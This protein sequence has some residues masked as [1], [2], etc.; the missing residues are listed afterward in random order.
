MVEFSY[1]RI[2][3]FEN[4][5]LWEFRPF[6]NSIL[7]EFDLLRF[8]LLRF[9]LMRFDL[10]SAPPNIDSFNFESNDD[11]DKGT[12]ETRVDSNI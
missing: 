1:G 7:W 12:E 2:R 9:E 5:T 4:S 8:D 3:S 11:V 10:M 6:E